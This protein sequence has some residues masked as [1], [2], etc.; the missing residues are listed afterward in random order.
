MHSSDTRQTVLVVEYDLWERTFAT[1]VLASQGYA[2]LGASNG[3]S[4]LRLA[5]QHPCDLILLDLSLPEL[6]GLEFLQRVK[7]MDS[8][9]EVPVIVLGATPVGQPVAA[10]GCVPRPLEEV[11]VV[12]EIGRVLRTDYHCATTPT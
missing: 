5:E 7:T 2:V 6:H 10:E 9:R 11:R 3:A 1:E 8:T 4:A 12:S